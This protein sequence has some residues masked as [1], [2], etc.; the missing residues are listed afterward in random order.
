MRFN[1]KWS[2]I[3]CGT[4]VMMA[5]IG[6]MVHNG[7]LLIVGIVFSIWNYYTANYTRRLED[8]AIRKSTT[9]TKG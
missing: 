7:F 5:I 2:Y 4:N 3:V 8:E 9:E 6:A 1:S